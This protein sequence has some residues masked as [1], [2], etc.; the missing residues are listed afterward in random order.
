MK[1]LSIGP[2]TR[3][4]AQALRAVVDPKERIPLI[5]RMLGLE[6]SLPLVVVRLNFGRER[7]AFGG[8]VTIGYED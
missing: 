4:V 6:P 3:F 5:G 8:R 2:K 1:I 7:D